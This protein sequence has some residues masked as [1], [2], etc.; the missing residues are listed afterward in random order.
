MS[1]T[2]K[3]SFVVRICRNGVNAY[4]EKSIVKFNQSTGEEEAGSF[5]Q[6]VDESGSY[7]IDWTQQENQSCLKLGVETS[8]GANVTLLT[9][10]VFTY[11]DEEITF[12]SETTT[13]EE[14][15]GY[16]WYV[17]AADT[18]RFAYCLAYT[19]EGYF[20]YLRIIANLATVD[21][22]QNR[23]IG[24]TIG[25]YSDTVGSGT[26]SGT[27]D[28][29]LRGTS[30]STYYI[31]IKTDR[32]QLSEESPTTT[33]TYEAYYGTVD[34]TDSLD[35]Y[36][37][38]VQWYKGGTA[39]TDS[40]GSVVSDNG[41]I[42]VRDTDDTET[43]GTYDECYVDGSASFI[44]YLV[45]TLDDDV[46]FAVMA[47][48]SQVVTDVSDPYYINATATNGF[49]VSST[50]KE[51]LTL[52]IYSGGSQ[53]STTSE[54]YEWA[55]YNAASK[56]VAASEGTGNTIA[57]EYSDM[58][59]TDSEDNTAYGDVTIEVSAEFTI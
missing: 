42:V 50:T 33:L 4:I 52:G 55:I 34:I 17:E 40:S 28:V 44:A 30:G 39:I 1:S 31:N 15:T 2:L 22:E 21:D 16:S 20:Y 49:A 19:D 24:Y 7:S 23:H 11:E 38:T 6:I 51:T 54:S 56:S 3:S 8:D 18:P 27:E 45:E 36:D 26:L 37:V 57:I 46:E 53:V 48:D 10:P 9:S 58:A 43:A 25:Y 47:S 29:V 41:L 14:A 35:E 5:I 32:T 59:Y 13:Y 12:S